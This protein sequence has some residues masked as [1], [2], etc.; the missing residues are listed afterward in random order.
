MVRRCGHMRVRRGRVSLKCHAG[1]RSAI[2]MVHGRHCLTS[3]PSAVREIR[4]AHSTSPKWTYARACGPTENIAHHRVSESNDS[5]SNR[6]RPANESIDTSSDSRE[7]FATNR[8]RRWKS[9][10]LRGAISVQ[11]AIK[12]G[13]ASQTNGRPLSLGPSGAALERHP[14]SATTPKN[15]G[16]AGH[17][18]PT[19]LHWITPIRRG[20]ALCRR[21]GSLT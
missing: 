19:R 5:R 13:I 10:P 15:G 21:P 16:A 9:R 1:R 17:R 8:G 7:L 18:I 14:S 20:A 3:C 6:I 11:S 2:F 4:L 12:L